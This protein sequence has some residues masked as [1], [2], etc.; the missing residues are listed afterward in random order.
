MLVGT[1]DYIAPEQALNRPIDARADI[2]AL[3]CVTYHMLSGSVPFPRDSEIA[4][5]YAHV[6]DEPKLLIGVPTQLAFA[7]ARAM[8]KRPAD[9]FQSAG[10]FSRAVTAGVAGRTDLSTERPVARG[11][12]AIAQQTPAAPAAGDDREGERDPTPG[13]SHAPTKVLTVVPTKAREIAVGSVID[14]RYRLDDEAGRGGMAVVYRATHL[15]LQKTVALKLMSPNLAVDPEFQRRFE[16]EARAAS[17]IDHEHVIPV[18]DFGDDDCGLY[19]VMRYVE[20]PNLRDLMN[21]RGAF[22]PLRAVQVTEQ[23]ASGLDAAHARGLLHR[24]VKPANVLVEDSTSRIFL[25]DFGLVRSSRAEDELAGEPAAMGTEWYMAP[26]RR[27][28][29]ETKLGDVYSLGCVLWE[30]LA[31]PGTPLPAR[32]ADHGSVRVSEA[33]REVVQ[34]AVSERPHE[35]FHSAGGLAR[36][37][38]TALASEV[39]GAPPGRNSQPFH[40]PL[41]AGLG[42]RVMRL[43]RDTLPAAHDPQAREELER[44]RHRLTEP[45]TLAIA[46]RTGSGKSTLVNALIGRWVAAIGEAANP[47]VVTWFRYG[48]PRVEV[49]LSDGERSQL[50][51]VEDDYLPRHFTVGHKQIIAIEVWLPARALRSLTIVEAPDDESTIARAGVQTPQ[52]VAAIDADAL[53]FAMAGDA[54]AADREVLEAFRRR[55]TD[56]RH[57]SA[58]NTI[59]VLTR[60]DLVDPNAGWSSAVQRAQSLRAALGSLVSEVLPVAGRLAMAANTGGLDDDDVT[61]LWRLAELDRAD[62]DHIL[63]GLDNAKAPS[64]P[65]DHRPL[66]MLGRFGARGALELADSGDPFTRVAL[67]R[68]LRELSGVE[69]LQKQIDGLQLRADAL[70]ADAALTDLEALSWNYD[71]GEL[72]NEIDALRLDEPVLELIQAFDRCASGSIE[73]DEGMLEE[74]ERLITGRTVAERLGLEPRA[75]GDEQRTFAS[76]RARAWRT[77]ANGGLASFQGQQVAGKVD[78]LYTEIA[79]EA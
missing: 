60:A 44:I 57:A 64:S 48:E 79:L 26:E 14:D 34:T 16:V 45:L 24:D 4:K 47:R 7:V 17:E 28:H 38:R 33:L 29:E 74:L 27:N 51:F 10:D 58:V 30:M 54:V 20:G 31:G 13:G 59:G 50:E 36:A 62:R 55:F 52:R 63:E 75:P 3:G 65:D 9:R 56:S 73:L 68:R 49:V 70:K 6:N 15:K 39:M 41:S 72:R 22:D 2:Y 43:C 1:V 76:R 42:A 67:I 61:A 18:Y 46:G 37:A 12:A 66:E 8:A 78:D 35:R 32:D 19:L 40:E 69:E 77:W 5:I 25:A 23:V 53:V 71:L 11:R 21:D